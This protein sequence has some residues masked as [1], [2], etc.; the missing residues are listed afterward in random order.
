M[1]TILNPYLHF[2]G[3]AR[4]AMTFYQ[5]VFGGDLNVSTYGQFQP[6]A[7]P[8]GESD[9]VMHGQIV[10]PNGLVLMGSDAPEGMP[11]SQGSSISVSLSGEDEAELRGYW[12]KLA[13]G[14]TVAVPLAQSPWG[15]SFGMLTDRFGIE[16]L[17][18]INSGQ[19]G[20]AQA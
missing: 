3:N 13:E 11:V 17:V 12:D 20:D 7:A 19:S 4:E 10:A 1:P 8:G 18:N 9:K 15:D 16:W 5:S 6:E 14:A 2:T